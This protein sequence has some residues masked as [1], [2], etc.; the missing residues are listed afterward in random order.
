[1]GARRQGEMDAPKLR[2]Q[3]MTFQ[4]SRGDVWQP[5]QEAAELEVG[6]KAGTRHRS[7]G[8]CGLVSQGLRAPGSVYLTRGIT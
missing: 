1:M 7:W 2:G 5:H 6:G 3:F 8:D 4:W